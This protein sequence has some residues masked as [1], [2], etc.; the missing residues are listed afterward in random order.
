[1]RR[2]WTIARR[3]R[4]AITDAERQLWVALRG[5]QLGGFRFRRQFPVGGFP[6][7]FACV[8]ARLV[9]EVA[10]DGV[11]ECAPHDAVRAAMLEL[12]GYRVLRFGEHEVLARLDAVL[13][14]ILR[15]AQSTPAARCGR[16]ATTTVG[17][18]ARVR[19]PLCGM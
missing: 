17:E 5:R 4:R 1:M 12:R 2:V 16:L 13:D 15:Q 18:V 19:C 9:V 3:L 6:T 8:E 14:E 10:P 7:D 11:R